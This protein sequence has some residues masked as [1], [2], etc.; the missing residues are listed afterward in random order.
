[1]IVGVLFFEETDTRPTGVCK[2]N[3]VVIVVNCCYSIGFSPTNNNKNTV[4][5]ANTV[6]NTEQQEKEETNCTHNVRWKAKALSL[7]GRLAKYFRWILRFGLGKKT[8]ISR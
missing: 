2:I 3:G 7:R 5:F 6:A 1:M 8:G 4:Y